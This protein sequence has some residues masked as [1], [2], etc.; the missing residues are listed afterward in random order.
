MLTHEL[1]DE[2]AQF[3]SGRIRRTP[4]EASPALSAIAGVSVSLKLENLQTTGSFKLRGAWFRLSKLSAAERMAGIMTCSAG[5][6]GKAVA[7]A[8]KAEG[9]RA[10]ICVPRS[11]DASKLRGIQQ[12]GAEVR[13]SE[14]DGYD[15]TQVWALEIAAREGIPFVHAYE[16]HLVMAGNGGSL[17]NEIFADAPDARTF[18][19]PVGGG[20]M[21]AGFSVAASRLDAA[22]IVGCQ[23]AASP[24]LKLSID[25]GNAVTTLPVV[26]TTAGGLEG[27]L[28]AQ[29]F[30]V[31]RG[32]INRVALITEAEVFDAVRWLL[33]EH[34]Y[35]MEPSA[36]VTIAAILTGK[37]GPLA[38]PTVAV[39]SG[40]NVSLPVVRRILTA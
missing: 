27:G 29:A 26:E 18:L 12:L 21:I 3:L 37:C 5:N 31:M 24:A 33:H 14:F 25:S 9:I 39:I 17:A 20:G 32:K 13:I 6:H 2:A 30:E 28:G 35:L 16:D 1:I 40:R 4:I 7:Y 34:Q 38:G 36:A 23:L 22:T 15:D 8:A 10:A 11:I 19:F